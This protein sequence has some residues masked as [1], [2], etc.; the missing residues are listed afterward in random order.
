MAEER[1]IASLIE[2]HFEELKKR[3]EKQ[4]PV[5]IEKRVKDGQYF[6]ATRIGDLVHK[7]AIDPENKRE[8]D[9]KMPAQ[10]AAALDS[11]SA[12]NAQP[13][14]IAGFG[15]LF[16]DY[17]DLSVMYSTS[18]ANRSDARR[19]Y[20]IQRL[21]AF[22]PSRLIIES[23]WCFPVVPAEEVKYY[24]LMP[25]M[26]EW[27]VMV[28]TPPAH[29]Y[30]NDFGPGVARYWRE[31]K[32]GHQHNVYLVQKARY[33]ELDPEDG[34]YHGPSGGRQPTFQVP[35][36]MIAHFRPMMVKDI[37]FSKNEVVFYQRG[38]DHIRASIDEARPKRGR[39]FVSLDKLH[40][41]MAV[42]MLDLYFEYVLLELILLFT[43]RFSFLQIPL[44]C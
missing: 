42:A 12:G 19:S 20:E 16:M 26:R 32:W 33:S 17:N 35:G 5:S 22:A 34:K 15:D 21:G 6:I 37:S 43:L 24:H 36:W 41:L 10:V 25:D 11:T 30:P 40:Q 39:N 13:E 8:W 14:F 2:S 38:N 1:Q 29:F 23:T 44:L 27:P 9:R 31:S 3:G 18:V 7:V 28:R 4:I